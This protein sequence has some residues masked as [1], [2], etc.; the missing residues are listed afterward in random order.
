MDTEKSNT[1]KII[2]IVL[3]ILFI[4]SI[5]ASFILFD[6]K[7][8]FT[9]YKIED[10]KIIEVDEIEYLVPYLVNITKDEQEVNLTL[11]DF[12]GS[13]EGE[14]VENGEQIS[15]YYE[16][17]FNISIEWFNNIYKEDKEGLFEFLDTL[18]STKENEWIIGKWIIRL[19]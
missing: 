8:N 5:L 13:M 18:N 3:V 12:C 19:N 7:K 11:K 16:E 4:C 6:N 1:I 9:L 17:K 10:E 15:C 2:S 14:F